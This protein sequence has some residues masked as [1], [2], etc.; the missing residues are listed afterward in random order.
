MQ[1]SN[2]HTFLAIVETGSLV[3][4][5][6]QLN[7]TQSTVT[8]RLQTLEQELGQPLLLRRKSGAVL[9]PAGERLRRYAD[10]ITDLWQQA[11]QEAA[12]PD[13]FRA[14]CNMACEDDLWPGLGRDLYHR[15]RSMR[16]DLAVSVWT[17][18][19]TDVARWMA[20]G[21]SELA[22]TYRPVADPNVDSIALPPDTLALVSTD[23]HSPARF[24]PGYILVEAGAA[25]ARDHATAYADADIARLSTGSTR[26]ALD[27]MLDHG[28]SAYLPRR[29]SAPLVATGRLHKVANAPTFTRPVFALVH[30]A[31]RQAWPW[32][33]TALDT[34]GQ[35]GT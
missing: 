11:R 21:R 35:Q 26:L 1:I 23:P 9:T 6:E 2:L 19:A 27:L 14:V 16:A 4:A 29:L 12:L 24:D 13:G 17:G 30:H 18:S 25:F 15:I 34:L 33:D 8:A 22:L 3:R 32:F 20:S 5:A 28:G 10:T 7:V 31:A